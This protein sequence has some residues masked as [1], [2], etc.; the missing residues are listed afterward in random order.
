MY[1]FEAVNEGKVGYQYRVNNVVVDTIYSLFLL[2]V[3]TE[4]IFVFGIELIINSELVLIKLG[5]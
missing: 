1:H 2:F 4:V 5:Y 3:Y